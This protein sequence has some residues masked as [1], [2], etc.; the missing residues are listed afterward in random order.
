M[1]SNTD[2]ANEKDCDGNDNTS[3]LN[4]VPNTGFII[5]E[6]L[7]ESNSMNILY[8]SA[9]KQGANIKFDVQ[10]STA[11]PNTLEAIVQ[12]N[13]AIYATVPMTT[14]KKEAKTQAFDNAL[15]FARKI[16]YTI[17]VSFI[18]S[19]CEHFFA[20]KYFFFFFQ[21]KSV[22]THSIDVEENGRE[23]NEQTNQNQMLDA[24]NK[25]FKMMKMLGWTGGALGVSGNGI[26]EPIS[27][28]MQID[29]SGLGLATDS[30]NSKKL[31]YDFF[32]DYLTKYKRDENATYD[33]V[34]SKDFTKE[35]R[36]T[37]HE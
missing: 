9:A 22:Y 33:L 20:F 31:N 5:Y 19:I 17:K 32:V 36:K 29:R 18:T 12:I 21:Q 24:G 10:V 28:E 2:E 23:P 37:L 14:N 27:I 34:F 6:T 3:C 25:G 35:E 1:G 11:V 30:P 7:N 26:E 15:E 4:R 8:S 16:H 13:D